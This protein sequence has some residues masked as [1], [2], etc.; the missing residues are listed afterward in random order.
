MPPVRS[1]AF[2]VLACLAF[3]GAAGAQ[4]VYRIVGPDGK[5][6]FSDKPP[7]E[8]Q[9]RVAPA[10]TVALPSGAVAAGTGTLPFELRNASNRYPVTLYTAP[11]CAACGNARNYL[12]SRGVPYSERTVTSEE[13]IAALK[14]IAGAARVPFVTIGSQQL[15]GFAEPEWAQ[16]LDAAG[17]PKTS[18]LPSGYR[19]PP[20][21]P[22]VAVQR[23]AA[24]AQQAAQL[25]PTPAPAP[26]A[27]AP[28]EQPSN[29]AGIRF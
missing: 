6:T 12:A 27:D 15:R 9:G 1:A 8:A 28:S 18:Q 13:D 10:P 3:I 24:P 20:A 21:A 26:Q 25:A 16:Y 5:V 2:A 7:A 14:R 17:Y 19:N 4:Q 11:D 29:P 23:S 22:L